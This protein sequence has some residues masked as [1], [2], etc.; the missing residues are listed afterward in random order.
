V[1]AN[2]QVFLNTVGDTTLLPK[3]LDAAERFAGE[4]PSDDELAALGTAPLFS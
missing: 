4:R 2:P 1:L 3:V